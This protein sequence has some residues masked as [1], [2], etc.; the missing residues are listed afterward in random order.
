[1]RILVIGAAG[2]LGVELVQRLVRDGRLG[3]EPISQLTLVDL[4]VAEPPADAGFAVESTVPDLASCR[5]ARVP[6][7][8]DADA[9]AARRRPPGNARSPHRARALASVASVATS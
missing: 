4:V 8:P 1:M 7:P 9:L 6:V 3:P 5:S 2:M